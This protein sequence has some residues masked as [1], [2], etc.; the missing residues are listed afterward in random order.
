MTAGGGSRQVVQAWVGTG[1]ARKVFRAVRVKHLKTCLF[2]NKF[3]YGDRAR[4]REYV[5]ALRAIV[6]Y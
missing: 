4:T 3:A 1:V 2:C 6:V 5:I